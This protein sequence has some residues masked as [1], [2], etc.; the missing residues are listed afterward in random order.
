MLSPWSIFH[1]LVITL[2]SLIFMM[3]TLT[4]RPT[5]HTRLLSA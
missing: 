2:Q 1:I 5:I 3:L 4:G